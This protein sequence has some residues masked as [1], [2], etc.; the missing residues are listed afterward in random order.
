MPFGIVTNNSL[1][2]NYTAVVLSFESNPSSSEDLQFLRTFNVT[3]I[4]SG[5]ARIY[6]RL[7][8]DPNRII[9]AGPFREAYHQGDVWIFQ[10]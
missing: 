8:F 10:M 2:A 9:A 4:Y 3:Y 7:G 6:G 5:P 1:L